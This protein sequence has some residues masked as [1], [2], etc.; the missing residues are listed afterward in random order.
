MSCAA[1]SCAA[2][3]RCA[4]D[5]TAACSCIGTSTWLFVGDSVIRGVWSRL[6]QWLLE[7][8]GVDIHR[9]SQIASLQRAK[10]GDGELSGVDLQS[11]ISPSP[12]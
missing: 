4:I 11:F 9:D 6:G 3:P 7:A 5:A 8:E 2:L 12:P 10:V 1:L